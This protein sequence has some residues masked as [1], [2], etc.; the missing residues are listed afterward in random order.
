MRAEILMY[1]A[2]GNRWGFRYTTRIDDDFDADFVALVM[3]PDNFHIRVWGVKVVGEPN[4]YAAFRDFEAIVANVPEVCECSM[5]SA[6][7]KGFGR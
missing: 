5:L 2:S 1:L 7:M 6:Y 4:P 3:K